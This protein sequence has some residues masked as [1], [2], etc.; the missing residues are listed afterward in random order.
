MGDNR[1]LPK[2]KTAGL[3]VKEL[4]EETLIY[5]TETNMAFCLNAAATI[6][7]NR[8]DGDSTAEDVQAELSKK[9]SSDVDDRY[10]WLAVEQFRRHNVLADVHTEPFV[11][12]TVSR[13]KM[14]RQAAALGVAIPIISALVVPSAVHAA[15]LCLQLNAACT[16]G[17][18][19][20]CCIG[21]TCTVVGEGHF[22][23]NPPGLSVPIKPNAP[24]DIKINGSRG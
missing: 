21:L 12:A 3:V 8:C 22:C 4:P 24:P 2:I 6:I 14:I 15:S 17:Q 13:R 7:M 23:L 5:D 20:A 1:K 19:P 18:Q 10:I 16:P 11:A 9:L